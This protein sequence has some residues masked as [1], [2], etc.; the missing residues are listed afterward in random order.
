[1]KRRATCFWIQEWRRRRIYTAMHRRGFFYCVY[2]SSY[3]SDALTTKPSLALR[4]TSGHI[5]SVESF[6]FE[7]QLIREV[8]D[9][10]GNAK[11]RERERET[12][13]ET[14]KRRSRRLLF[15][16][17]FQGFCLTSSGKW[18]LPSVR[19]AVIQPTRKIIR[20]LNWCRGYD[21]AGQNFLS[22]R[23]FIYKTIRR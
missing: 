6:G 18:S 19:S 14:E 10:D 21:I 20:R 4:C 1:M 11:K 16:F 13:R 3:E 22:Y 12:E 5:N 9:S 7:I 2:P 15:N 8:F 23:H 17:S